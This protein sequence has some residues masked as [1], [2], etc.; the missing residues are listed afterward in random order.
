MYIDNPHEPY[1]D[2][3]GMTTSLPY[4]SLRIYYL[5]TL[6][7]LYLYSGGSTRLDTTWS[8]IGYD[9]NVLIISDYI[10]TGSQIWYIN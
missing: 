1:D 9:I 4:Q 8:Q 2:L 7:I 10:K 6:L 3:L 5:S